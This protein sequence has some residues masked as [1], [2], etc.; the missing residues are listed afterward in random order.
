MSE[1]YDS[2]N[3]S[4]ESG[5]ESESGLLGQQ[6]TTDGATIPHIPLQEEPAS[7]LSSKSDTLLQMPAGFE[8]HRIKELSVPYTKGTMSDPDE[9]HP[10]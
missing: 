8:I 6:E 4:F 5:S 10:R 1:F 2:F 3:D 9:T 7:P